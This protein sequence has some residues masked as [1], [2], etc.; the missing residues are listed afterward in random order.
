MSS[1]F[2]NQSIKN[3]QLQLH[4]Y[5]QEN[6]QTSDYIITSTGN[7]I[8]RSSIIIKPQSLEIPNGRVILKSN[9]EVK[10]DLAPVIINKYTLICEDT[11]LLPCST[12]PAIE[13]PSGK[14]IPLTIGSHCYIGRNCIIE[15]AVIGTCCYISDNCILSPRTIL[16]DFVYVLPNTYVPADTVLPPFVVVEGN[17]CRIV[18]ELPESITTL[19]PQNALLRY[20]SFKS[21]V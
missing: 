2:N 15:S 5:P 19:G 14:T 7:R 21:S 9:M 13:S 10:C 11:K 20:K 12:I 18:G 3:I 1:N 6:Y 17:P 4:Y 16:K 8:S